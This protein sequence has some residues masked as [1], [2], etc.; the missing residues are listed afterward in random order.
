MLGLFGQGAGR[1]IQLLHYLL[2]NLQAAMNMLHAFGVF[3]HGRR[4]L[5][6]GAGH[7][8][9][10]LMDIVHVA[11]NGVLGQTSLIQRGQAIFHLAGQRPHRLC[12]MLGRA[13]DRL[14][15]GGDIAGA[16]AGALGQFAHLIGHHG[17]TPP[18]LAG[19]GGF[20]RRV[21]GQQ[22]GLIGDVVDH[23]R[24]GPDAPHRFVQLAHHA[25]QLAG[26]VHQPLTG[27][28]RR[29]HGLFSMLV[30]LVGLTH[31]FGMA[32]NRPRHGVDAGAHLLG[33]GGQRRHGVGDIGPA[34]AGGLRL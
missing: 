6:G 28:A 8:A 23:L 21:Q 4:L 19:T 20:N 10:Y 1:D 5:A 32:A 9:R 31:F 24:H 22:I 25:A 3:C 27:F 16:A 17:K 33:G 15:N 13:P 12:G 11:G 18:L 26:G 7:F 2:Q 29:L 14:N 30:G 34:R